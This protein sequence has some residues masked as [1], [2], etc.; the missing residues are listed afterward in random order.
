MGIPIE[1]GA[2][3]ARS[4]LDETGFVFLFAPR[5]HPAMKTIMPIR[6]AMGV[7]TVFNMLG[8]LSNPAAPPFQVVGVFSLSA[9]EKMAQALSRM[10]I[11]RAFVVHGAEGWDEATPLGPYHLFD[12][13]QGQ[14]TATQRDPLDVDIARCTASDLTGQDADY[15]ARALEAV[16][17]GAQGPHA[18]AACLSAGLALEVCGMASSHE[19]G[20]GQARAA[21]ADGRA[22]VLLNALRSWTTS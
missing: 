6:R 9:A 2:E 22:E 15:N 16:L 11:R 5:Y 19:D 13:Q 14:V 10:K 21:I 20:I 7:R 4:C 1:L 18:D 3:H 17:R 12:V 8:P